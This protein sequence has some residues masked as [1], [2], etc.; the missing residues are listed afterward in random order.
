MAQ[1]EDRKKKSNLKESYLTQEPVDRKVLELDLKTIDLTLK[2]PALELLSTEGGE[3][4]YSYLDW[5]GLAKSPDLIVLSSMHHYYY[6]TEELSGIQTVVN[7][8][9]LNQ[10]KNV[11][12]FFHSIYHL[13]PHKSYFVGCFADNRNHYRYFFKK[14]PLDQPSAATERES[15]SKIPI[16]NFFYKLIDLRANRFMSRKYVILS[17]EEVG[18]K[19]LDITE[20]KGITYFC[21]RKIYQTNQNS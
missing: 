16:L 7:L 21:S 9:P 8:L 3:S 10:V 18:F 17:L 19:V 5:L 2:R 15:I 1:A 20:L 14:N 12:G 13:I 11:K 6:D 4:F